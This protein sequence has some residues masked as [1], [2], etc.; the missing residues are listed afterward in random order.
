MFSDKFIFAG[1][2]YNDLKKFV[3]APYFRKSF[4]LTNL[5]ES[6]SVTVGAAG[7]YRIWINGT[8]ITK[9]ILAP[10]ISNPDDIVYF[11]KYD[12][13]P[14]L[15]DGRN[16]LGFML[17]N[18]FQNNPGGKVWDFDK[19]R[20]RGAPRFS[21]SLS[22][23]DM[24]I[25]SDE[26]VKTAPSPLY[27]DDIRCGE[28]Y[29]A[30]LETENWNL[31]DFDDSSWSNAL[32]CEKPRGEFRLCEAEP[33]KPTGERIKPVSIIKGEAQ[34]YVESERVA[35]P[36]AQEKFVLTDGYIYDFGVN[37]SGLCE[38]K[39]NGTKG[40]RIEM[41]FGEFVGEN[42]RFNYQ[43]L[44][45]YP[46][47]YCQHDVYICSGNGTETYIPHFTYHG[48]RYCFITGITPEQAT[49]DLLT[50]VVCNSDLK[51]RASFACSDNTAN[52][53]YKMC[54]N[55]DLSNFFYFPND[56]PQREKNGWTGDI[57]LSAEHMIMNFSCEKSFTEWIRN[58]VKA[59]FNNGSLPSIVPTGG[60]GDKAGP[61]W[62]AAL[63]YVP[64]FTFLYT[65]DMG[66]LDECCESVFRY[67][68][69]LSSHRTEK[70]TVNLYLGDWCPVGNVRKATNEFTDSVS[71]MNI[72]EKAAFI[73]GVLGKKLHRDFA[74]S[75]YGELRNAIREN[76]IDFGSMTA[77]VPCQTSQAM[78][79]Y[80]GVF[81][82]EE[83][84]KAFSVLLDM[85]HENSDFIDFGILGARVLFHVLSA[86]GESD[87]AYKMICRP[88]WPS[89][90]NFIE[91]GYT[92][93]PENFVIDEKDIHSL[94]HHFFGD[95]SNWFISCVAGLRYNPTGRK[96]RSV[97]I[98]PSFIEKLDFANASFDSPYGVIS[99]EWKRNADGITVTVH[100]PKEV[101]CNFDFGGYSVKSDL[102]CADFEDADIILISKMRKF[103]C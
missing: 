67:L 52:T 74:L 35:C 66:I 1:P 78:A 71:A 90:G 23:D 69:F 80:Y 48:F 91:R 88:E 68:S 22:V 10:Y 33:V 25:E 56:C 30:R 50:Y 42:G 61:S 26:S 97:L 40:Q 38:L 20:F 87:L 95:I 96:G 59:Q 63:V 5:P 72:C 100:K 17:G 85:I 27:F 2:E 75:L 24:I 6:C 102:P 3:P 37:K 53:L 94:N 79:I 16:T 55:S 70:G 8:E 84:T 41:Q 103:N 86:Y 57:A 51:K 46:D 47:G 29:D 18:G 82:E 65:G 101:E 39:I 12:L 54:C 45:F 60:W 49:E 19:T 34:P 77:D 76:L 21:F 32:F 13:V 4:D 73:F 58:A 62:D 31:P 14:Y 93:L 83:K 81:N 44:E 28:R 9:G 11:D 36:E 98:K 99:V 92:S 43:N 15:I 64:Y 7:F 89:Y